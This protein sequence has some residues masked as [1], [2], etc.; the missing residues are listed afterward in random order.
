[1]WS[2]MGSEVSDALVR[3]FGWLVGQV[4]NLAEAV[5]RGARY[6]DRK[7]LEVTIENGGLPHDH[8]LIVQSF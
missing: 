4:I 2:S 5:G 1:M 3:G 8:Q 6:V 7:N